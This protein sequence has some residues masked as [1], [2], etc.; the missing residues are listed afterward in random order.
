LLFFSVVAN[1]NLWFYVGASFFFCY[2]N[3]CSVCKTW[4]AAI[5]KL[6]FSYNIF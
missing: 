4:L 1:E 6:S 3:I 2:N 5:K